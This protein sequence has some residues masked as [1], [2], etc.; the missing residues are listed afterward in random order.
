MKMMT[1]GDGVN[2]TTDDDDEYG[3]VTLEM[4]IKY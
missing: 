1:D 4:M 3:D 2:V